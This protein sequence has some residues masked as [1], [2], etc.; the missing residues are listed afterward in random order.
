MSSSSETSEPEEK[1]S[2]NFLLIPKADKIQNQTV[3]NSSS[4][5]MKRKQSGASEA[6]MRRPSVLQMTA[7]AEV[8]RMHKL[9]FGGP[10][11]TA[12]KLGVSGDATFTAICDW[13]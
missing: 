5:F 9:V 2:Q 8:Q 13:T 4:I 7:K 12:A 3:I 1:S 6:S 11:N 10:V